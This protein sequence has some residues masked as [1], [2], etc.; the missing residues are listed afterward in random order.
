MVLLGDEVLAVLQTQEHAHSLDR[1]FAVVVAGFDNL[2][3]VK[4]NKFESI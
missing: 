3:F 2:K 1:C 4:Q